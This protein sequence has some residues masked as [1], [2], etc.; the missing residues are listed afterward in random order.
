MAT[1]IFKHDGSQVNNNNLETFGLIWL[2][3]SV[4]N[5]KENENMEQQM[6]KIINHFRKF[7]DKEACEQYIKQKSE[8][9]RLVFIVSNELGQE[10]VPL[11]HDLRQVSSIYVYCKNNN[12]SELW[13]SQFTKVRMT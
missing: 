12:S 10:L 5:N 2:D 7:D 1:A 6:R 11:I 8:E 3:A 13:T 4:K 9:D